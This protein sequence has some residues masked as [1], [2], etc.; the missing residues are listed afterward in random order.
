M[1]VIIATSV[2]LPRAFCYLAAAGASII[3]GLLVDLEYFN[4]IQPIY[5]FPKSNISHQGAYLFYT[6]VMNLASFFAVAHL[7]SILTH[8]LRQV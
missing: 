3:Y 1:F 6:I 5:F 8:R 7:S 4:L 2:M